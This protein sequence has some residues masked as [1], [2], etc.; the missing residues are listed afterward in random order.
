[1][2]LTQLS[3]PHTEDHVENH[4]IGTLYGHC[5]ADAIG[6]LTEFMTKQE[7]EQVSEAGG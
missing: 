2:T 5:M 3:A 4:V 6:L 1:M 7:A